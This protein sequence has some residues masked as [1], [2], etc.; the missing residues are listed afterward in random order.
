M[1][2]CERNAAGD[3]YEFGRGLVNGILLAV[4]LW[5]GLGIILAALFGLGPMEEETV[6]AVLMI[7]AA[8][9]A[10]LVRPYLRALGSGIRRYAISSRNDLE[11]VAKR[12]ITSIE[13]LLRSVEP[14]SPPI[15]QTRAAVPNALLRQ[16]LALSALVGAYLQY[17]FLDIHLQIASMNSITV[18]L[19]RTSMT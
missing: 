6:S 10:I 13:D 11:W 8:C 15:R 16:S 14:K 4:P 3:R 5:A 2:Q 17:Y 7:A 18:F 12:R 19:S 1:A 9:A